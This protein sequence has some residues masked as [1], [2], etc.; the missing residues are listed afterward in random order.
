MGK[1]VVNEASDRTP[2][3]TGTQK[4][5]F[6]VEANQQQLGA[7]AEQLAS[8]LLRPVVNDVVSFDCADRAYSRP[9]TEHGGCG[10]TVISVISQS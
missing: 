8:G 10:K 5:F 2:A 7:I 4:S 3:N 1:K 6:I 9:H